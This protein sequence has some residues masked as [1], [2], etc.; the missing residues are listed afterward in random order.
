MNMIEHIKQ[1]EIVARQ[2]DPDTVER[3]RWLNQ[4]ANYSEI[5]LQDLNDAPAFVSGTEN[6]RSLLDS[7]DQRDRH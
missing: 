5:F 4:V 3:A 2:L 6:G 1:L 7:P